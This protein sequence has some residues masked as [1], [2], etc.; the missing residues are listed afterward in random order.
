MFLQVISY[1]KALDLIS[2]NSFLNSYLFLGRGMQRSEYNFVE[3]VLFFH[4]D[5]DQTQVTDK[6][7]RA[8]SPVL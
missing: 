4:L 5:M 3:S 8:I 6:T 2:L 1:E 7:C